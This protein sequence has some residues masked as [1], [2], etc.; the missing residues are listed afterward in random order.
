VFSRYSEANA[1]K[2]VSTLTCGCQPYQDVFTYGRWQAMGFQVQR[3]EKAIRL[4]LIKEVQDADTEETKRVKGMSFVFCRHQVQPANG[5]STPQPRPQAAQGT[6]EAQ[7]FT[8]AGFY[9]TKPSADR[10]ESLME[11]WKAL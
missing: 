6:A 8:V 5:E 7:G 10:T 3:G 9:N 4:P 2:V 1:S 11:G